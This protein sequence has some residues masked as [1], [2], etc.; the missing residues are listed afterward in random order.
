MNTRSWL[1]VVLVLL[2]AVGSCGGVA[3]ND[4]SRPQGGV[5]A[6]TAARSK[7]TETIDDMS[8]ASGQY[9]ELPP[10]SSSFFW[11]LGLGNW[12]VD[13]SDGVHQDAPIEAAILA[14]GSSVNA[15]HVSGSGKGVSVDLW[16]QLNHPAGR[17]LD[18]SAYSGIAFSARLTGGNGIFS[19]VFDGNGHVS[20]RQPAADQTFEVDAEWQQFTV[21]FADVG[22]EPSAVSSVD[23]VLRDAQAAFDLWV[24]DLV[25]LCNTTCP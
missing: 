14:D 24:R 11:R 21:R 6:A 4:D 8:S 12:F 5:D 9:P 20:A 2:P 22:L 16:A 15:R 18:L 10:G 1:S 17:P 13:T 23:F 19:V 25:L 3:E 7:R